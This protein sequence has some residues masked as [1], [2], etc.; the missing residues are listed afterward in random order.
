MGRF[1]ARPKHV[2]LSSATLKRSLR[3]KRY[4][5]LRVAEE[6]K[7]LSERVTELR[8]TTLPISFSYKPATGCIF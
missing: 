6:V 7:T 8:S 5:A 1:T 4:Q 2:L 3:L